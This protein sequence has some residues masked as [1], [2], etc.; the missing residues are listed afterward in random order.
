[1]HD[2]IIAVIGCGLLNVLATAIISAV[3]NRKSRL[4]TIEGQLEEVNKRLDDVDDKLIKC[5]KDSL[6]TQLLLMI[7]DYP[8]NIEGIMAV[9]ERYFGGL[10][11]NWYATALF[12]QWLEL[13]EIAKPEW[14]KED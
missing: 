5:E 9:G 6:R 10:H 12:N 2:I 3:N 14:F 11:G 1:M 13:K 7:S 8:D 4:K